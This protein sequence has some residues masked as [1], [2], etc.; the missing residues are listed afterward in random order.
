MLIPG[1]HFSV[2]ER[3]WMLYY[4]VQKLCRIKLS[5]ITF[6]VILV[7]RLRVLVFVLAVWLMTRFAHRPQHVI[8]VVGLVAIAMS[9]LLYLIRGLS[10]L[11]AVILIVAPGLLFV[12]L[13]LIAELLVAARPVTE[14][15]AISER[16]GWC[17]AA[18]AFDTA[19]KY[20]ETLA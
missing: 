14:L 16:V 12:T 20:K 2:R 11:V 18:S 17:A 9:F 6:P 15:Y 13:G 5:T 19:D 1:V 3:V 10:T 7:I 4:Q 8:G